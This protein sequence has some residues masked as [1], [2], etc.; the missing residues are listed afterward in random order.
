MENLDFVNN[1]PNPKNV[2]M[3]PTGLRYGLIWGGTGIL[4]TLIGFLTNTDP[5]L[6]ETNI[7]LKFVYGILGFGI[8]VWCVVMAI[9]QHRDQELGGYITLGRGMGMGTTVGLIAGLVT[10]AYMLLHV[11]V[12][13]PGWADQMLGAITEQYEEMGMAED[14]IEQAMGF[15]GYMFNPVAQLVGGLI[16]GVFLGFLIG[17]VAGAI[18]KR[19]APKT[20]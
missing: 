15:V 3:W 5:S 2:S 13:N 1:A 10:G 14:Q 9:K 16:N 4:L 18:M 8:A 7:A 19:D 11:L 17:L 20:L 12:I 6:P